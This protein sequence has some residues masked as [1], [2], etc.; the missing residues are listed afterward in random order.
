[1]ITPKKKVTMKCDDA[2]FVNTQISHEKIFTVGD[3]WRWAFSDLQDNTLRGELAEFIVAKALGIKVHVRESWANYDLETEDG[4]QIEVKAGGFLQAW[5]QNKL[6]SPVFSR[7][8]ARSWNPIDGYDKEKSYR[9]HV[10][11][12]CVQTAKTHEEYNPLDLSQWEFR[13]VSMKALEKLDFKSLSYS[14]LCKLCPEKVSFNEL[15]E[16]M[17]RIK[18]GV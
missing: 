14:S 6:S 2:F 5:D 9:A 17:Y 15:R 12:F 10:Y 11:I 13:V 16:T 8:K 3:F 4:I 1:M 7:L 18:I